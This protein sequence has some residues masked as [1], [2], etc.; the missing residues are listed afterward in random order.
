VP[1]PARKIQL[2][3]TSDYIFSA[4]LA[5]EI[6]SS[7]AI[8]KVMQILRFSFSNPRQPEG[9]STRFTVTYVQMREGKLSLHIDFR[10]FAEPKLA[11]PNSAQSERRNQKKA[12][13]RGERRRRTGS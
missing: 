5:H 3:C 8:Q 11:H 1:T 13:E 10:Q 2:F 7:L 4:I 12:P 6:R 9:Y